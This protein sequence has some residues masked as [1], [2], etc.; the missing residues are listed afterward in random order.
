LRRFLTARPPDAEAGKPGRGI[1]RN[2][3]RQVSLGAMTAT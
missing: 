1:W 3:A 2:A